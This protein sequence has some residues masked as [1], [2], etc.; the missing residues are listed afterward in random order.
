[1]KIKTQFSKLKKR[2]FPKR[3]P[4][5]P[6][7][8][9]SEIVPIPKRQKHLFLN[10]SLKGH[11]DNFLG[12]FSPGKV[13]DMH[14]NEGER[15]QYADFGVDSDLDKL[16]E[17]KTAFP[18]K[19]FVLAGAAN[20][21]F[22]DQ[23]F[24]VALCIDLVKD[25]ETEAVKVVAVEAER[26]LRPEGRFVINF[27]SRM[28][29]KQGGDIENKTGRFYLSEMDEIVGENWERI[30][31]TAVSFLLLD[32]YPPGIG[33]IFLPLDKLLCRTLAVDYAA[34]IIAIYQKRI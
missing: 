14:C 33:K 11:L 3:K 4:Q 15:M 20:T 1:M 19:T 28:G 30:E 8:Q 2:L 18:Q 13:L 23:S 21:N 16:K 7:Q 17:V 9:S 22:P 10:Q 34:N 26:V 27:P 31:A 32:A 24:D 6:V 25:L 12:H 5:V 29:S